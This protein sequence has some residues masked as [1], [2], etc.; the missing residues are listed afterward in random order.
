YG[1]ITS[2][3]SAV[4][5]PDTTTIMGVALSDTALQLSTSVTHATADANQ[6]LILVGTGTTAEVMSYGT[7][8]LVSAGN[9]NL[10]YLRRNLYGSVNQSHSSGAPFVRLDGSIFQIAFDPGMAGTTPLFKFT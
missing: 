10:S 1:T 7:A 3:V 9:Y 4:A 8:A 2:N 5:D 6:T